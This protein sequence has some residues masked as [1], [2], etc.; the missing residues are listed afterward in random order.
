M[1][2]QPMTRQ[3]K[4]AIVVSVAILLM[5]IIAAFGGNPLMVIIVPFALVFIFIPFIF[6]GVIFAAALKYLMSHNDKDTS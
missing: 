1:E 2:W 3:Q 6:F 4:M 5:A